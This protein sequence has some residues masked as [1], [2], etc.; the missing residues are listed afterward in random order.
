MGRGGTDPNLP[1]PHKG[2][3]GPCEGHRTAEAL[4][5]VTR[6]AA[7]D[8]IRQVRDDLAQGV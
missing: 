1:C 7:Q 4:T 6:E 3:Y 2:F 8:A 5:P